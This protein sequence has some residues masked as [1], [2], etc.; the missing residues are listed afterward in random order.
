MESELKK[1]FQIDYIILNE[2]NC[3]FE[4]IVAS[5]NPHS[6]RVRTYF[7]LLFELPF[8]RAAGKN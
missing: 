5:I 8:D 3:S 2:K 1:Y 4:H 7:S 6:L